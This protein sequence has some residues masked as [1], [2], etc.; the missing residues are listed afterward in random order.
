M[1]DRTMLLEA[2][3][4]LIPG[5]SFCHKT[6]NWIVFLLLWNKFF[7]IKRHTDWELE[8]VT[9]LIIIFVL[10]RMVI[11]Y[12]FSP[13]HYKSDLSDLSAKVVL[14]LTCCLPSAE[15]IYLDSVSICR[16]VISRMVLL[17][18]DKVVLQ[19]M[20]QKQCNSKQNFLQEK[21]LLLS[22]KSQTVVT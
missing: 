10:N 22:I 6:L 3:N 18:S 7:N 8:R 11:E 19:E 16:S 4:T 15:V 9:L 12:L 14:M 2:E 21:N 17:L 20:K 5:P 13:N 1:F